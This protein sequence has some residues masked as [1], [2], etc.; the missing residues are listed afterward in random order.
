[1]ILVTGA[2]G[3]LGNVLCRTLHQQGHTQLRIFVQQN[4]DISHVEKFAAEVVRG[5]IR[6]TQMVYRAVEG[7]DS[8]FHLAGI[9]TVSNRKKRRIHDINRLGTRNIVQACLNSGAARLVYVSSTDALRHPRHG[10]ID[11][12]LVSDVCRL[13]SVYAKSKAMANIE[14]LNGVQKGLDAVIVCPSGIIGPYDYQCSMSGGVIDA[15]IIAEK[16]Q[17]YFD[18]AY[19][20]VDV[21][22]VA[23]G[24]ISAWQKGTAGHCYVLS[25]HSY[26]I[27]DVIKTVERCTGRQIH[28]TK[29]PVWLVKTAAVLAPAVYALAGKPPL[30]TKAAVDI[31]SAG[32]QINNEKARRELGFSAR[33]LNT[34]IRDIISWRE[35][36]GT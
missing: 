29:L 4:E 3:H 30:F 7:C 12:T 21:R 19:D 17:Y 2:G 24:M 22:D 26:T 10:V 25:G 35:G 15:Y 34:T 1:M 36:K 13:R 9:V 5:D 8:V 33:S 11:E 31:L 23:M 14:V 18:G 32:N 6:D 16:T 28:S 20:F 27:E